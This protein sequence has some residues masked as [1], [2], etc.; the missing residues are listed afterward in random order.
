[1]NK[2]KI[3]ESRTSVKPF[4]RAA[5]EAEDL[6]GAAVMLMFA[7]GGVWIVLAMVIFLITQ[8]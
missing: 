2:S 3:D 6:K 5:E 1:M 7:F 8:L 4:E